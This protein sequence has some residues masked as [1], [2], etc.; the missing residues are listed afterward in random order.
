MALCLFSLAGIPPL[1]GF[2]GKFELFALG[3]RREQRARRP[4]SFWWLAVI[5]VLNSAVGAY[6]Y[7]RIVVRMYLRP[8]TGEPLAGPAAW[9]TALAV[10]ACAA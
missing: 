8:P 5:G 3:L 10:A 6:Y 9:P 7:L 1:A 2:W 4:R